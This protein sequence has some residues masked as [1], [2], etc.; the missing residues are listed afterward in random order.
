MA[1][2]AQK[3]LT[4]KQARFVQEYLVDLNATQAA[5]RAGYS[6]KTANPQGARLLANVSVQKAIQKASKARQKRVEIDQDYVLSNLQAIN[7]RC[8]QA[9]PLKEST[10]GKLMVKGRDGEDVEGYQ[11]LDSKGAIRANKLIGQ[12]LGM[13]VN[14]HEHS[15]PSGGPIEVR[16]VV[17][18]IWEKSEL[19]KTDDE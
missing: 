16:S 19:E 5:I 4:P 13:F 14:K 8:M 15:G 7:E 12:H 18:R 9:V 10:G 3:R 1:K 6:K 11:M 17:E 2:A